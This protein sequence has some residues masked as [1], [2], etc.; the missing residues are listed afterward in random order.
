[1]KSTRYIYKLA[2]LLMLL[3]I[4]YFSHAQFRVVGYA[5]SWAQAPIQ[6][7]KLTHINY[8]FALPQYGGRL[9]A[10]DNPGY[11]QTIVSNAHANGVKV[12]I[13]IGGWSDNGAPLDPVF[14][15][16]GGDAA[17]RANFVNDA[18]YIVNTYNLDG[19]DMDW[20]YPDAG[21][22]SNNFT[23][24]MRELSV[25]L[26]ARG[27]G[28]SFAGPAESYSAAGISGAVFQY[29][30]F[31]N[32]MAYDGSGAH[33]ST[34]Q[35]AVDGLN[36]YKSKG[37]PA[38]KCVVGVPFYARPSWRAYSDLVASGASPNS[39]W[40][41]SDGYNG[42]PTIKQK[43]QMA[44]ND[45]GGI[46]I[47]QLA[48]DATGAN[49]L[50]TAINDVVKLSNNN[51]NGVTT[52]GGTYKLQ[53]RHSG[54]SLDINAASSADG[55][56]VQQWNDNTCTCQ[57][58]VFTHL[59]NGVYTILAQHSGKSLDVS[60]ISASD[61]AAIVQWPYWANGNQ[62]FKVV[63]AGDGYYKLFAQ[64]S[65]KI[66][67]VGG[68]ST[69][70]GTVVQQWTDNNQA[71]GQW[72]LIPVGS[73]NF[74]T[75]LQAENF[76][77]MLGVQ[78]EGTSDAGGG[79]NVGYI[80][81]G[82]WMSYYAVNFPTSGTYTVEYR[83]ASVS[84]GRVSLDLNAG[85]IQ[86]G[87]VNIPATGGW[88]NWTTVTQTVNVTAGTYNVGLFAQTGG[89]NINWFRISKNSGARIALSDDEET[90]SIT[91]EY[92]P[93]KDFQL[94]P[95]PVIRELTIRAPFNTDGGTVQIISEKGIE[96][97]NGTL[98]NGMVDVSKLTAGMYLFVYT[99]DGNKIIKNFVKQ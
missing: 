92:D 50:L 22:S 70:P 63:A 43:T 91:S 65:G 9:K 88:Q 12:F 3:S 29:V 37:C 48:M 17:S 99:R 39:D 76:N 85:S 72:K 32:I 56:R 71:T 38:S 58:F 61:G 66:I 51:N 47:W 54:L 40:S 34:Y 33:H 42:I 84:G 18:L 46:M 49:S 21:N 60:S 13:A 25:A 82:D 6:Y 28:L 96:V 81:N 30:D 31:V 68:W 41:G 89:W 75:T 67:E 79:S 97:F 98:Q 45:A 69:T 11:L 62:Q 59:G 14:E 90:S 16:I 20:E 78:T 53:N 52:L 2:M 80:D 83:V 57:N 19:V 4:A 15:S 55:A 86:L 5:P 8:S 10:I 74:S 24:L 1:M 64:H 95:N 93:G 94:F 73:S 87:A 27:K 23:T 26:K 36:L 7:S 44:L 35:F 77:A